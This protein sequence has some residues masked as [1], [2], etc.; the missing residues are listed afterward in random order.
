MFFLGYPHSL[1]TLAENHPGDES[2]GTIRPY[3]CSKT[4]HSVGS[5]G[6]NHISLCSIPLPAQHYW[7]QGAPTGP[8]Q[9]TRR[10]QGEGRE[11]LDPGLHHAHA[12]F[13]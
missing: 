13:N 11:H 2:R 3:V 6:M 8:G 10:E 4:G 12:D 7:A 5:M 9:C 1:H